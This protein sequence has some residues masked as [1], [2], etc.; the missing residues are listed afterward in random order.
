ME[1]HFKENTKKRN[2]MVAAI[3]KE[4]GIEAK[5]LGMPSA[6]YEIGKFTL[7]RDGSIS[8]PDDVDLAE[9]KAL[10]EACIR[11]D[12]TPVEQYEDEEIIEEPEKTAETEEFGLTVT[13]PRGY[14]TDGQLDNLKKLIEAK[15]PLLKE[16]L[17]I[18]SLPVITAD[19]TVSFPWFEDGVDSEHFAAYTGLITAMC[20]FAKEAKRVTAKEKEITNAKYEFRCFLLRLGFIGDE[21]K[22]NR[23]LLLENL[24]GSS[25]FKSGKGKEAE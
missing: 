2:T 10:I 8:I 22:K 4:L 21:F 17:R 13:L 5:Y 16:A 23:K 3:T 12:F 25:A 14:F 1:L 15:A 18:D 20:K 19:E 24:S 9:K 11:N 6:A 7:N